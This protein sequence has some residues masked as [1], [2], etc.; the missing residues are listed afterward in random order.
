MVKLLKTA[1]P[2]TKLYVLLSLNC[3]MLPRDIAKLRPEHLRTFEDGR[4]YI[5]RLR[6]KEETSED[7]Y[8]TAHVLWPETM[9]LLQAQRAPANPHGLLLL[10]R[11]GRRL[12]SPRLTNGTRT[13]SAR[14]LTAWS[15]LRN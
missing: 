5:V 3:G 2:R 13:R 6:S 1:R 8:E 4:V 9:A 7:A 11:S 15:K 14:R 10:T 12:R